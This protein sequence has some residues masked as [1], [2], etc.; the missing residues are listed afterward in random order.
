MGADPSAESTA[1]NR[2]AENPQ[3][4][5]TNN[6][7]QQ[8]RD[9]PPVRQIFQP[10]SNLELRPLSNEEALALDAADPR[11]KRGGKLEKEKNS[12]NS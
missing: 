1:N 12:A 6:N 2:P 5:P 7:A 3:R 9:L 10:G 11:T 4:V 8:N